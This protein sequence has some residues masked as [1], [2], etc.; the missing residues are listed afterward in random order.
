MLIKRRATIQ[1]SEITP[2]AVYRS[3]RRFLGTAAAGLLATPAFAAGWLGEKIPS[4]LGDPEFDEALT[5]FD[6][7]SSHNNYYEFGTDKSDP[8]RHAHGLTIDPW[9]VEVVGE[10]GKPGVYTLEDIL[11]PHDFEERVYRLRCVEAW[12]MVIPWIGI[13]L[14]AV[15]RRFEPTG[16]AK[17]VEFTTL[18]RPS[19]MPGQRASGFFSSI[20]FPYVEGL[21]IDEAMHPLTILAVGMYGQVLPKQNGAP[22]RLVVPW[23]YGFKS[24]KGIV[25]IRLTETEPKTTWNLSA[26]RE[27]GF[28]ANVNPEVN[29]PRWSQANERRLDGSF[30]GNRIDTRLFNGYADEV[31]SLYA[32]MNLRRYY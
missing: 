7:A 2:E 19:E 27:Y 1:P 20:D 31:A 11:R 4:G 8:A 29:H 13:P 24:I 14:Q 28:Y 17:Y 32:G 5:P 12:S 16:D 3:R 26:P 21:R 6:L 25:K 22:L 23:K 9:S 30:F 15:L 18:Y 10:V